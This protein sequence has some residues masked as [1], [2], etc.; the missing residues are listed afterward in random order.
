MKKYMLTP[1]M[2][3][4]L[5]AV[6]IQSSAQWNLT[7]NSNSTATSIL[8]TTNAIPLNLTTNNVSRLV[9]DANGKI[10]IGTST[11]INLLTV[12]GAGSTPAASWV[13]AG[14]PLFVGFGENAVGNADYILALAS[15]SNNARPVFVGRRSRGTLA[16]PT[17]MVNNDFIMSM[18]ASA[19]DGTAFQNPATI[20]FFVDGTVSSGNVPARISFVTGSNSGNRAERL[21]IGNTG[22]ISM[23]GSQL[24]IKKATGYVGIG[25]ATPAA[26]LDVNGSANFLGAFTINGYTFPLADGTSND[27]LST[28]GRGTVSWTNLSGYART[29]LSNLVPT[30][31]NQSLNPVTDN[32]FDLGNV[33]TAWKGI[34]ANEAYYL[35]GN[36]ILETP[37]TDNLFIGNT[38]NTT[39]TSVDNIF[40]GKNA[41]NSNGVGYQNLFVGN[42]AGFANNNGSNN[43]M[44]GWHAGQSNTSGFENLI[45]GSAAGGN[46]TDGSHNTFVGAFTGNRNISSSDNTFLGNSAGYYNQSGIDNS[47]VGSQA[48]YNNVSGFGNAFMGYRAGYNSKSNNNVALGTEALFSATS[49]N[50]NIAIGYQSLYSTTGSN[51]VAI[52]YNTLY[53]SAASSYNSACGFSSLNSNTTGFGNTALGSIAMNTNT[54][55]TYNTGLGY[56]TNVSVNNLSNATAIGASA[57]VDASDKVRVGN[58]FVSSIG[59]QVTWTSFSDGRIKQNIRENVPGLSF[60]NLLR[61]VTYHFNLAKENELM[62]Q[63]DTLQWDSK[64]DIEKTSFTGFVA[65]DVDAASQKINYDFSGVDKSGKIM[66]LRYAEFVVPLVKAVQELSAK[67]EQLTVNNEQ[68]KSKAIDQEKINEQLKKDMADLKAMM[69]QLMNSKSNVLCPPL[70]GQ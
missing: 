42:Y 28:N 15:T 16:V 2:A 59:G 68:L 65:Q 55:G 12:K 36:K 70:A 17:A 8:G 64:Y 58:N 62:G 9:I 37:G 44:M 51:N 10:G 53:A 18:L 21:K 63:K 38:G 7:G 22:D 32:T 25:T 29:D 26:V 45:I 61:P 69:Q 39:N 1:L 47:F 14:A 50:Q 54:T 40:I 27:V 49:G 56:G 3:F 4:F 24:T 5:F 30:Y 57:I 33:A 66:G 11:P 23:N 52:G 43:T 67:N 48:G 41:G 13:A 35:G 34:Y 60:I 20:D 31:I 6:A 46:N 19:H